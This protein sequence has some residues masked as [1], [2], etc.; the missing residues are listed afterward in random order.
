MRIASKHPQLWLLAMLAAA[1]I[2]PLRA[3]G[4]SLEQL[5]EQRQYEAFLLQAH[6]AVFQ[7]DVDALFL[8]GKAYQLGRGVGQ[9]T[10]T[11]RHFYTRAREFG[12]ARASHNLGVI[13]LD[14]G[15]TGDAIDLLE[16]ALARGLEMPTLYNLGRAYTPPDPSSVFGLHAYIDGARTAG[17]YYARACAR[18][19]D[20]DLADCIDEA[21]RQ[22]LRAYMM[23]LKA[24]GIS[25]E[26]LTALRE[27]ALAW[28]RKGMDAGSGIAW[29]N[30]G[31]L[32]LNEGDPVGAREAFEIGV[33]KGVP[34][35]QFHLAGLAAGGKGYDS[36]DPALALR[37]Y[38]Q[39]ATA[40][41]AEAMRPAFD[42]LAG[43]LEHEQDPDAL[44][45]GMQRLQSLR[46]IP[47][48]GE[49]KL[50]KLDKHLAWTRFLASQ[51]EASPAS[52][53]QTGAMLEIEACGL[54][55]TQP[56]GAA[57]NIGV[58]SN[59]R[60]AAY[61]SSGGIERL[62]VSGRVDAQGCVRHAVQVDD[63]LH[64]LLRERAVFALAFPNYSLPL[65]MSPDGDGLTLSLLPVGTPLPPR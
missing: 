31:A 52:L 64:A 9:D 37:L 1:S 11:A 50:S 35:A 62:A 47:E 43:Q 44:A 8:L 46:P 38:E 40:G 48:Y 41:V 30:Y 13:A 4:P 49:Y 5:F 2:N 54:G 22:Y 65:S 25:P 32:L 39:A 15:E 36:P 14:A 19:A 51:R 21:S 27:P 20:A 58:N 59:W 33:T 26:E 53:P 23:A 24:N 12:S 6:E 7:D 60:L 28:L 45:Q 17:D 18:M 10:A 34:Q 63:A 57:Y 42:L 16:E 29:T 3:A 55:L 56:H 61:P